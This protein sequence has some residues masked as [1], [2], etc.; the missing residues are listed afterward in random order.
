MLYLSFFPDRL[1]ACTFLYQIICSVTG[2]SFW[3]VEGFWVVEIRGR[4]AE[5][6]AKLVGSLGRW[7]SNSLAQLTF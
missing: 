6:V 2:E 3:R 5:E 7:K 4:M 1:H